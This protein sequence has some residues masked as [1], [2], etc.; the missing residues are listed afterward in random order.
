MKKME[1]LSVS[2]ALKLA[3]RGVRSDTIV[4]VDDVDIGGNK[5]VVIA[6]PCTVEGKEQLLETA[7][8]VKKSGA[9]MLRGGAFKPRTL[10]YSFQGLGEEGLKLLVKA[11]E[12]T[13]LP[14][15]TEVMSPQDVKLIAKYADVLQIG[16][17]NMQNF[18]LLKEVGKTD[19]PVLLKRGL[20][21]IIDEWMGSAEYILHE[22]NEN[23]ILCERG[24]RSFNKL[25]RFTLDIAAIPIIKKIS[26]L[27]IIVDPSHAMGRRDLVIPMAKA[28]IAAGAD[29]LIVEVHPE[30]EKALCDGPQQLRLNGFTRLM[31]EIDPI[32]NAIGRSL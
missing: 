9:S 27:P 23:V 12:E 14:I 28:A 16:A 22:G 18:P 19:K 29:G 32:A 13:G 31:E 11:R 15:V 6:G 21:A 30:P 1:E 8:S 7:H 24:I 2:P 10:P 5:V 4:T 20:S 3:V 25:T 17:R 26:H